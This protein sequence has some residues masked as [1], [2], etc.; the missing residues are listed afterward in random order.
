LC[1]WINEKKKEHEKMLRIIELE[2]RI[3][4]TDPNVLP[5]LAFTISL[6]SCFF[7]LFFFFLPLLLLLP[8]PPSSST[9]LFV[10]VHS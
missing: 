3:V 4:S 2:K 5:P 10:L 6:F 9:F 8:P 1:R 7:L